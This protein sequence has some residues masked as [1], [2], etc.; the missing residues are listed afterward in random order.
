MQS[1][2]GTIQVLRQEGIL[3]LRYLEICQY[4]EDM[5]EYWDLMKETPAAVLRNIRDLIHR[6]VW[7]LDEGPERRLP[8]GTRNMWLL[9]TNESVRVK[10]VIRET[11]ET[12]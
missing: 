6:K 12:S 7:P 8:M 1:W 11:S 9:L 3:H 10:F 2:H 5:L 4:C